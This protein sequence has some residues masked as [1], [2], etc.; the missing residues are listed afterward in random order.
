MKLILPVQNLTEHFTLAE[1]TF[2]DYAI[3]HGISNIPDVKQIEALR[4]L[5][6]MI[7]EPLRLAINRPIIS[8]SG[9]RC[10]RVN[11]GVG[12]NKFSQHHLGQADDF[13]AKGITIEELFQ[14]IQEL[15]LPFDQLIQEYDRWIHCSYRL[16]P[17]GEVWRYTKKY[18]KTVKTKIK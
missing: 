12:G 16:N 3:R 10:E 17:R 2:S 4:D 15:K 5:C 13:Y 7:L 9:F 14:V 6:V 8:I 11:K 18:G 1:L